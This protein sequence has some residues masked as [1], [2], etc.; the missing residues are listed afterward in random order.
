MTATDIARAGQ[1][2]REYVQ[3]NGRGA[4]TDWIR[5]GKVQNI[6]THVTGL[7]AKVDVGWGVKM[8][9][10]NPKTGYRLPFHLHIHRYNWWNPR[11]WS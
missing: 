1:N 11:R 3:A 8:G 5:F 9:G 4:R 6:P 7:A 10:K 2:T